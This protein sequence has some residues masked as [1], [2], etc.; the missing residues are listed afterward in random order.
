MA[1]TKSYHPRELAALSSK[2]ISA[3]DI[4]NMEETILELVDYNLVIPHQLYELM[5]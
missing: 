5:N 4:V 1:S 2:Q 3:S